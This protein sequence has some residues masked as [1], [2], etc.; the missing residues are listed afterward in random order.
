AADDAVR[1]VIDVEL[2]RHAQP[3]GCRSL[4][5]EH[6]HGYGDISRQHEII[7]A[8]VTAGRRGTEP[9][10]RL[11][12]RREELL[13]RLLFTPAAILLPE[14]YHR[15]SPDREC[16][17]T[18]MIA[19]RRNAQLELG[20]LGVFR[21]GEIRGEGVPGRDGDV[22][23]GENRR[24]FLITGRGSQRGLPFTKRAAELVT[25]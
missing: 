4:R 18:T 5:N 1:A 22:A 11:R 8:N 6:L 16:A 3:G 14:P 25:L 20:E 12:F 24:L 7:F 9:Q 21:P 10:P 19:A 23:I 13:E 17:I 15:V 2:H